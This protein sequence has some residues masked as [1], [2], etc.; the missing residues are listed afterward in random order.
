MGIKCMFRWSEWVF[1]NLNFV[2]YGKKILIVSWLCELRF[3]KYIFFVFLFYI[4]L[5][6]ASESGKFIFF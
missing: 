6:V 2:I 3:F 4:R 5:V 1:T